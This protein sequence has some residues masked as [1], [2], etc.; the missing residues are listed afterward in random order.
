MTARALVQPDFARDGVA[1][2]LGRSTP[3]GT[4]VV[5]PMD[6]VWRHNDPYVALPDDG[7]SLRLPEDI[8]RALYD[9]LAAHFGGTSD[10]QTLRKD[11]LAERQ[12]VDKLIGYL[13]S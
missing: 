13:V 5:M 8:A 7:T 4:Q 9:A 3:S 11:Y 6:V 12:R 1:I 2:M 10:V